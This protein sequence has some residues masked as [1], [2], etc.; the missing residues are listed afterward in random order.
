MVESSDYPTVARVI[1]VAEPEPAP[2]FSW[3]D[4]EEAHTEDDDDEGWG[5]V[6]SRGGRRK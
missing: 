3:G 2:G 4:Y 5:V 1:R 6:K